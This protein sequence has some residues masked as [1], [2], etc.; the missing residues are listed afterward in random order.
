V[1]LH[2]KGG[3]SRCLTPAVSWTLVVQISS[4][5]GGLSVKNATFAVRWI[6]PRCDHHWLVDLPDVILWENII[7]EFKDKSQ[8]MTTTE[9][10]IDIHQPMDVD[11]DI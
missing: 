6:H 8:R 4:C 7:Q 10:P 2:L 1:S 5:L 3:H 11:N 9:D